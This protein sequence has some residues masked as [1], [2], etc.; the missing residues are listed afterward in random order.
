MHI[1]KEG[2]LGRGVGDL[3][4]VVAGDVG[5]VYLLGDDHG[6]LDVRPSE[7]SDHLVVDEGLGAQG[8]VLG[9]EHLCR[10]GVI[11]YGEHRVSVL[12]CRAV[13]DD[14]GDLDIPVEGHRPGDVHRPAEVVALLHEP[15][16]REEAAPEVVGEVVDLA[17]AG[18][19]AGDV[20]S[21]HDCEVRSEPVL[22]LDLLG[23]L[24][25]GLVPRYA[26][27]DVLLVHEH[28]VRREV[29]EHGVGERH[30]VVVRED[31]LH[32][33]R[34]EENLPLRSC[35]QDLLLH[36]RRDV[37]LG[38]IRL[39]PTSKRAGTCIRIGIYAGSSYPV[40][41]SSDV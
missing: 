34:R 21:L 3:P 4:R 2:D 14:A 20:G 10:P 13:V 37:A 24:E 33:V 31:H 32:G 28:H 19:L 40:Y 17:L 12:G 11:L 1:G 15:L 27:H 8:G 29:G 38:Y 5:T 6:P 16:E 26:V 39:R 18:G 35:R 9:D 25:Q 22:R 23:G 30:R 41:I 7:D 36:V